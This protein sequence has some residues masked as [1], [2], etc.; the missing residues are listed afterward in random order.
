MNDLSKAT[1]PIIYMA[2]LQ[3][4]TDFAFRNAFV[5][6]FET[7]DAAFS[8]YLISHKPDNRVYRDVL[9]ER[10][11]GLNLIPQVLGN[12]AKEIVVILDELRKMGYSEVNLNL[13]C[14]YPMV[15]K[16]TM[17]A[18]LLPHPDKIDQILNNLFSGTNLRISVKMRLGLTSKDD[19]KALVPILNR[20]PLSE[21]IIHGRTALQMYKGEVDLNSFM[22]FSSQ[23]IQP[24]CFNGNIFSLEQFQ[25]LSKKIPAI[26]RFML[27]RGIIANPL[28]IREIRTGEKA[29]E[30][31]IRS[32]LELL[33]D[34]LLQINSER[35]SGSSHILN[36]MKPYWEYFAQSL[37]GR[38]KRL[39][40]VKKSITLE[41]Y[42]TAV[43]EVFNE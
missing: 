28:L 17:G 14:P 25:T 5:S 36:K 8:P 19:W 39:K 34:K 16:K 42:Q 9:P 10:N 18:G 23:I 30:A 15:T 38:E 4:F 2:P 21:V 6:A 33:H 1:N 26:N 12:D 3:G 31:Q 32:A 27:G 20:Y 13:G 29:G 7:P 11:T 43:N 40:K 35:L 24:V 22:E 37:A 41:A